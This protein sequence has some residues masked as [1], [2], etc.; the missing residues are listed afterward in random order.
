[1]YTLF[2]IQSI[3]IYYNLVKGRGITKRKTQTQTQHRDHFWLSTTLLEPKNVLAT[4]GRIFE[5]FLAVRFPARKGAL[6]AVGAFFV[7]GGGG[8]GVDRSWWH[9]TEF[10]GML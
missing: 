3:H 6:V 8:G 7:S 10:S 1:M 5:P 9:A 4:R 2:C